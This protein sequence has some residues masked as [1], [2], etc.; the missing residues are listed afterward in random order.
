MNCDY[1]KTKIAKWKCGHCNKRYYC[2]NK[3]QIKDFNFHIG[4]R[5][6]G[7][8]FQRERKFA[9]LLDGGVDT[10]R[11]TVFADLPAGQ[12]QPTYY[13]PQMLPTKNII[14]LHISV[15]KEAFPED[16]DEQDDFVDGDAT[17]WILSYTENGKRVYQ[18]Y[19]PNEGVSRK[20]KE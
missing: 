6:T 4:A 2:G 5:Y 9:N 17:Q 20:I 10:I 7:R 19:S 15:S 18:L 14:G 11:I 16:E 1:C 13:F 12:Q 3:C 8:Y